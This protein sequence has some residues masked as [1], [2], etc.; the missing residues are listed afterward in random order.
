MPHLSPQTLTEA[1]QRRLRRESASHSRILGRAMCK[2]A[3]PA[4]S[5]RG[6]LPRAHR[7]RWLPHRSQ[8]RLITLSQREVPQA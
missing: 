6:S 4:V 7:M 8:S 2:Q 3:D 1:E 5:R